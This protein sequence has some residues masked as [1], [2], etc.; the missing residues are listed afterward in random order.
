M[1]SGL[2]V[3]SNT[4]EV[5]HRS[6]NGQPRDRLVLT[7][8]PITGPMFTGPQ[9]TPFVCTTIQGAVGRQPL[10]DSAVAPGY[11][12]TDAHGAT[13]RL[14]PQLLDR[15]LRQLPVPQ[16]GRRPQA[17]ARRRRAAGRHGAR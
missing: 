4:L 1:I 12:V 2:K 10:V 5:R 7:N 16:H 13:D 6:G 3:G 9:Q 14:Q 11:R 17:A 8:Y 15:D